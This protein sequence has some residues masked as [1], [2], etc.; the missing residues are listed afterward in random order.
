MTTT[1]TTRLIH[2]TGLVKDQRPYFTTKRTTWPSTPQTSSWILIRT[3]ATS[4]TPF[5]LQLQK[6]K[7]RYSTTHI[8]RSETS[9]SRP[10]QCKRTFVP[11]TLAR[12]WQKWQSVCPPGLAKRKGPEEAVSQTRVRLF[13]AAYYKTS[14]FRQ[15]A[16]LKE[17][18]SEEKLF[19]RS[20]VIAASVGNHSTKNLSEPVQILF[21]PLEV[22]AVC[23]V[24]VYVCV[25]VCVCVC[26]VCVY[27]SVSF[28][29]VH[30]FNPL[31]LHWKTHF[32]PFTVVI[33]FSSIT[34]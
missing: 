32:W 22:S 7:P 30:A 11:W 27:V 25:C 20:S 3:R 31:G 2:Q 19:L 10:V 26:V 5:S 9:H 21:R 28:D 23:V 17:E 12:A 18:N 33:S 13:F 29:R 15:V 6:T 14:L 4:S 8:I 16:D 34:L 1:R 24:Y